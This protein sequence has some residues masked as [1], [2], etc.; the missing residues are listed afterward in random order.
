MTAP[1]AQTLV[2]WLS[3]VASAHASRT[4]LIG[5]GK[6]TTYAEMWSRAGGMARFLLDD[7]GVA[8]G[9]RVAIIGANEP[10][11]LEAFLGILRGGLVAVPL[12]PMLDVASLLAQIDVEPA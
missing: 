6:E 1:P 5:D 8:P 4:A 12:N 7:A 3:A 2:G 10:A 9:S 11:Y